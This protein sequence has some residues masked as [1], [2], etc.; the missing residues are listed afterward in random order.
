[1]LEPGLSTASQPPCAYCVPSTVCPAEG[2]KELLGGD[3]T[4]QGESNWVRKAHMEQRQ[5]ERSCKHIAHP[6]LPGR[7]RVGRVW[8]ERAGFG[9][10]C[11]P[12]WAVLSQGL[13]GARD[14][15]EPPRK[16]YLEARSSGHPIRAQPRG[17]RPSRGVFLFQS[18]E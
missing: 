17:R 8:R 2:T 12:L 7:A 3:P 5:R 14:L 16:A 11:P 15:D 10:Q 1:M 6:S 13:P 9:G 4:F 18:P